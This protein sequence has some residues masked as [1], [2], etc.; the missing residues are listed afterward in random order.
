MS[1]VS[2]QTTLCI[3]H[4]FTINQISPEA[5]EQLSELIA[6]CAQSLDIVRISIEWLSGAHSQIE[7]VSYEDG[8]KREALLGY[9]D[10]HGRWLEWSEMETG[11][12]SD[13]R[14]G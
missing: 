3:F 14:L 11:R 8:I 1:T 13:E 5:R 2:Q 4:S 6:E 12:L 9:C 10:A 7:F